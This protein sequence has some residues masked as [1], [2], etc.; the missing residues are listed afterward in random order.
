MTFTT[1][2]CNI[3]TWFTTYQANIQT[4]TWTVIGPVENNLQIFP[5]S[6]SSALNSSSKDSGKVLALMRAI[7]R[8]LFS[9]L[10]W[11]LFAHNQRTDSGRKLKKCHESLTNNDWNNDLMRLYYIWIIWIWGWV[12]KGVELT[13]KRSP[14]QSPCEAVSCRCFTRK[15][16]PSLKAIH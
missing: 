7:F 2:L 12:V 5:F 13:I 15:A 4:K 10:S 3:F 9:T 14:V 11:R 1:R 6:V 8:N 16:R